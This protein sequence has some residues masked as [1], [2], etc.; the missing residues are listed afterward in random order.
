M[1]RH[2]WRSRLHA[3]I[4]AS[5]HRPFRPGEHDCV[6]FAAAARLA[7]RGEDLMS[8]WTGRYRTVEEG[9]ELARK[10]G[11]SDPFEG[12]VQGLDEVVPARALVGDLALIDDGT[13]AM[14]MGVVAGETIVCLGPRGGLAHVPLTAGQ[15]VWRQ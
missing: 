4:A 5:A 1:R 13:G 15:R 10:A 3:L 12:V 6:I 7:V 8:P 11:F 14:A 2:D 9:F